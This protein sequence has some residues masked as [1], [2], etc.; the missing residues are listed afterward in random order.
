MSSFDGR[1]GWLRADWGQERGVVVVAPAGG[2]L[3]LLLLL[4]GSRVVRVRGVTH[5]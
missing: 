4:V 2:L 3:L 1:S 5:R